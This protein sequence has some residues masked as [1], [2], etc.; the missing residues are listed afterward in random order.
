[1]S[2]M[3]NR[4]RGVTGFFEEIFLFAVVILIF[5]STLYTVLYFGSLRAERE[6][7]IELYENVDKFAQSFLG[8]KKII[9]SGTIGLFDYHKLR[10]ITYENIREDLQPAFNFSIKIIDVSEYPVKYNYTYGNETNASYAYYSI[11]VKYPANIWVSEEEIH[12]A[13]VEVRGW[14]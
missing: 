9:R 2:S 14:L 10:A 11:M 8:Y 5:L 1:M 12:V 4:E 13:M 3:R 6:K 7:Y